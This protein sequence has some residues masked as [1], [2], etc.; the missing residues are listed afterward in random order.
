MNN[1]IALVLGGSNGIGLSI[2]YELLKRKIEHV[3]ILDYSTPDIEL[4]DDRITF[5]RF[6]LLVEDFS[7]FD[8]LKNIDILIITAG[9]G[10]ISPF[11]NIEE[12]EIVN[13]L[14]V[15]TLAV[16][17]VIKRFY[18]KINSQETFYTAVLSSIAGMISSP[19]FAV[20]GATKAALW[21]FIESVNIEL[22]KGGVENRI[23]NVSPG[24]IAGT[25][26]S[27]KTNDV[28]LNADLANQIL[29]NLFA[30]RT[31]FI[32]DF[33]EVY[34]S[35]L[36]RYSTDSH[37]FGIQSYDYKKQGG[38][39]SDK[40]QIKVG[41]LSGTFDLFHIGHLNILRNA[42]AY[43]DYLVVG[44]HKDASHKGKKTFIP[45]GE[46]KMIL[47]SIKYVD[48]VIESYPE[49]DAAYHEVRYNY[50]FVGSDYKGTDRFNR[51]EDYFKD[52]DVEIVYFPYTNETNSTQL[53]D[54]IDK[55]I[56]K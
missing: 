18:H 43:C 19:L 41:Y 22:E 54:L 2:V 4:T 28:K 35:V 23:L 36:D 25:K 13:S 5:I 16:L 32:P 56:A 9:F 34:K 37:L 12:V 30:G 51:Y 33:E 52:K 15:N 6:N 20:Y 24:A 45:F 10:R 48:R 27:S 26:F 46:R 50:L 55:A 31:L 44:L 40:P 3:Y 47:E 1:K 39:I 49:D 7:D 29:E 14:K 38:R 53:R 17:R 42:K 21:R 11:E 8:K